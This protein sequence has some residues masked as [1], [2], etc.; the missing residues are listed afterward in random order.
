MVDPLESEPGGG[1]HTCT[2]H[3]R[4]ATKKNR[5]KREKVHV[6][7]LKNLLETTYYAEQYNRIY[8]SSIPS[9]RESSAVVQQYTEYFPF[10]SLPHK[11]RVDIV[12]LIFF[13]FRKFTPFTSVF[14]LF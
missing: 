2:T 5:K 9:P 3:T 14:Q 6:L 10:R 12:I 11:Q 7:F 1:L 13:F 4:G 8:N